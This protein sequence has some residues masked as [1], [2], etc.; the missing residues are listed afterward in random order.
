MAF[1]AQVADVSDT[2]RF[3]SL[4]RNFEACSIKVSCEIIKK[5]IEGDVVGKGFILLAL[6]QGRFVCRP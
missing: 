3:S 2:L 6:N 1:A 5:N 4:V